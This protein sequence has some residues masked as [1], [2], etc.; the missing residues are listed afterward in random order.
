MT[1]ALDPINGQHASTVVAAAESLGGNILG[2][3]IGGLVTAAV[4][5]AALK[6]LS[7]WRRPVLRPSIKAMPVNWVPGGMAV[8]WLNVTNVGRS[9]A[10]EVE[11]EVILP[12]ALLPRVEGREPVRFDLE[13][14][15]YVF[16]ASL[17]GPLHSEQTALKVVL[18]HMTGTPFPSGP[19]NLPLIIRAENAAEV[20]ES[21]S[22]TLPG[23]PVAAPADEPG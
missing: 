4:I 11:V 10:R 15:E 17:A 20:R 22:F 1:A 6:A 2:G 7:W 18:N 5:A 12:G 13:K 16:V 3:A 14:Q 21:V 9:P 8:I 19:F 23:T